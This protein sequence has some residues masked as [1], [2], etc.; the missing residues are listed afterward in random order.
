[1][2]RAGRD[3][4]GAPRPGPGVTVANGVGG[5]TPAPGHPPK[6]SRRRPSVAAEPRPATRR[7]LSQPRRPHAETRTA[8]DPAPGQGHGVTQ[9]APTAWT[10]PRTRHLARSVASPAAAQDP[11]FPAF[12]SFSAPPM[13]IIFWCVP[14]LTSAFREGDNLMVAQMSLFSRS[15]LAGM[16]DRTLSR[17]YSVEREEFRRE[18]ERHR[19]WGLRQRH[20]RKLVRSGW[21]ASAAWAAVTAGEDQLRQAVPAVPAPPQTADP[22]P[23]PPFS[24]AAPSVERVPVGTPPSPQH[25]PGPPTPTS[26]QLAPCVPTPAV[27]QLA[28]SAPAPAPATGSPQL[29]P[30]PPAPAPASPQLA[31]S[32]PAPASPQV[33]P[34]APA[35]ASPL[36]APSSQLAPGRG[37]AGLFIVLVGWC[38]MVVKVALDKVGCRRVRC[39]HRAMVQVRAIIPAVCCCGRKVSG[40]RGPP[41]FQSVFQRVVQ[42]FFEPPYNAFFTTC[43]VKSSEVSKVTAG[44]LIWPRVSG[45]WAGPRV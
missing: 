40:G 42:S 15:E 6:P 38:V 16:R 8:A 13:G 4:A 25:V 43:R 14:M 39:G 9:A 20:T 41:G 11:R 24:V 27:P 19:A 10:R 12:I 2:P 29:A 32:P 21:S 36:L 35:P 23:R 33:A 34:S 7:S 5:D 1:M 30:S 3:P 17:N 44:D 22:A 45:V 28:P 31:P 18:H 26:Q 37:R